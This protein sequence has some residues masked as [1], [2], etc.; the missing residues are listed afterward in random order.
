MANRKNQDRGSGG[1]PGSGASDTPKPAA[2]DVSTDSAP[3][4]APIDLSMAF[5]DVPAEPGLV[6]I[7]YAEKDDDIAFE[8]S[9]DIEEILGVFEI[10]KEDGYAPRLFQATEIAVSLADEDDE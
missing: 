2:K 3:K 8:I 1:W 7:A 6:Y 5:P 4:S 10:M 9:T